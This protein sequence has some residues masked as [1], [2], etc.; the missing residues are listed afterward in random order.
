M[1]QSP[2]SLTRKLI[3]QK[4]DLL[5]NRNVGT[6]AWL[7]HRLTGI[8]LALYIFLHLTVLGSEMWLGKG[9]FN[10]LMGQFERPY[11]R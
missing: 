6:F 1:N 5:L 9:V 4:S 2:V 11:L 10:R 8:I 3:N 7:I